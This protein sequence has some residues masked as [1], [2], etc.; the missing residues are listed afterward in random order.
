MYPGDPCPV[1]R[2]R[3]NSLV[4]GIGINSA[5]QGPHSWQH[6][7]R[8]QM[9]LQTPL[10]C[11][12]EQTESLTGP[13]ASAPPPTPRCH[14]TSASL[15]SCAHRP[16]KNTESLGGTISK[17]SQTK[18]PVGPAHHSCKWLTLPVVSWKPGSSGNYHGL[19]NSPY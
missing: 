7:L 5:P 16:H 19:C 4:E 18:R 9:T 1:A 11:T 15:A 14:L 2:L 10:R 17:L 6:L 8:K 12:G 13:D 3:I